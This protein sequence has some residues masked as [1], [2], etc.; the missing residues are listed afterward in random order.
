MH[1][2]CVWVQSYTCT[3]LL[4]AAGTHTLCVHTKLKVRSLNAFQSKIVCAR[5][6]HQNARVAIV[7]VERG[8]THC[9]WQGC[10]T[11][12]FILFASTIRR[13]MCAW[14]AFV[15]QTMCLH[16]HACCMPQ[17]M[18]EWCTT[19]ICRTQFSYGIISQLK[20]FSAN[21]RLASFSSKCTR[22]LCAPW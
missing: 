14:S 18:A 17:R 21:E 10:S 6:R 4:M 12:H 1:C 11:A 20:I 2:V 16:H 22:V 9:L 13:T 3:G 5:H 7:Q 8:E 15:M 19:R